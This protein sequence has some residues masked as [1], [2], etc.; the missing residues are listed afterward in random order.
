MGDLLVKVRG[1]DRAPL[2]WHRR[3]LQAGIQIA[4]AVVQDLNH[5][6]RVPGK[7]KFRRR[8]IGFLMALV[9]LNQPFSRRVRLSLSSESIKRW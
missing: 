8:T 5:K 1:I 3:P 9:P 2:G 4:V 6:S 7:R